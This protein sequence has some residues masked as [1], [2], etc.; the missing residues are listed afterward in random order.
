LNKKANL[1]IVTA[2]SGCGKT[3][4]VQAMMNK[5]SGLSRSVSH[6]TRAK[7]PDEKHSESYYFISPD[8]FEEKIKKGDFLEY[9]KIYDHYY[10]TTR[11]WVVNQLHAG[12]DV[13]LEIDCQGARQIKTR[14]PDS[15][16]VF[17]FPPTLAALKERL[18]H[19]QQ[20]SQS[21]IL[22]RLS[23]AQKE[24]SHYKEFEYLVL[25]DKFEAAALDLEYIIR[26]ARCRLNIQTHKYHDLLEDLLRKR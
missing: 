10:G 1:I 23:L 14:F 24:I 25:N 11:Q 18:Y 8:V 26:G 5:V 16:S 20:D 6:T 12:T 7:R 9:A 4:L 19:R 22:Q 13:I 21:V 17:I 3:T 2:P 15:L